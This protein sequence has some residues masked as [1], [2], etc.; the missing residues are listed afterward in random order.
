MLAVFYRVH[1]TRYGVLIQTDRHGSVC[2]IF[3]K[4]PCHFTGVRGWRR[5][6][7]GSNI[8][9][10]ILGL[11]AFS[12]MFSDFLSCLFATD[13][14]VPFHSVSFLM[15]STQISFTYILIYFKW[16]IQYKL[17]G[18][19]VRF[20]KID[21]Q[22]AFFMLISLLLLV[23][24]ETVIIMYLLCF[25]W[26]PVVTVLSSYY[27]GSSQSHVIYSRCFFIYV[28]FS[29]ILANK[30]SSMFVVMYISFSTEILNAT[31]IWVLRNISTAW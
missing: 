15:V 16:Y 25:C 26:L 11:D 24:E 10:L 1:H 4:I 31:K 28:S 5:K 30:E 2:W 29:F 3:H 17:Q 9:D 27:N 7:E 18:T 13:I 14:L 12:E 8:A 6:A 23:L 22:N 21:L 20:S 19:S